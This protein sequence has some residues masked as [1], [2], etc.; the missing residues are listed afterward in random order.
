MKRQ[1]ILALAVLGAA[2][3]SDDAEPTAPGL[4]GNLLPCVFGGAS[5]LQVGETRTFTGGEAGVLCLEAGAEGAEFT[6]VPYAADSDG[7][8]R[9]KVEAVGG[10]LRG[11]QG[12]PSP[13]LIPG[14]EAPA[15]RDDA[16]HL[17]LRERMSRGFAGA[18][19]PAAAGPAA[20]APARLQAAAMVPATGDSITLNVPRFY[21]AND[22]CVAGTPRRMRVGAV[23]QRAILVNDPLNP[24]GSLTDAELAAFGAEFDRQIYPVN[25]RNFGEPTDLDGNGGRVIILFTREVNALTDPSGAGGYVG[26]FFWAGDLFPRQGNARLDGC[27][28]SNVG[29]IFYMLTPNPVGASS[30]YRASRE[31]VL[32]T[33]AGTIA[34]ELQ[35]LI[36]ASRRIFVNNANEFEDAWLDE[37]LSH[38]AEELNFYAATG[39]RPRQNLALEQ[40]SSGTAADAVDRYQLENFARYMTYLEAPDTNSVLGPDLLETRGAAWAF[41]RYAADRRNG[42]DQAFFF[43][44]V[45]RTQVGVSNLS[46][47]IGAPALDWAQDWTLSVY[48]D[49][50]VPVDAR[51]TQPSWN[52][53]SIMPRVSQVYGGPNR[54]PLKVNVLGSGTPRSYSLRGG[55]ATYLRF[56][57]AA[58]ERVGLRL[59]SNGKEAPASL[60]FSL[61]RT[62]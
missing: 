10:N 44:L 39:L 7:E 3:C 48:T 52:F 46:I 19:R 41:L 12:P 30:G 59:T 20:V 28:R 51:Y 2:A 32:A 42:D 25:T 50:A 54:F 60:R 56:G 62:R 58:G 13:N 23:S 22:P 21:L 26:G 5:R 38:I 9:V 14:T 55:G 57:I 24:A 36:N 8:T 43:G 16:L 53:R 34:H 37:G 47:G 18:I 4:A 17:R 33:A 1:I 61:V 40:L 29:E 11:V 6:L 49:D 27:P 35:H 15:L 45:N 31:L